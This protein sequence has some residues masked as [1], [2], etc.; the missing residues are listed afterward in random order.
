M[1]KSITLLSEM[2]LGRHFAMLTKMYFGALT[3]RLE[4]LE[5]DRHYSIL[6]L[7][8]KNPEKCTQQFISNELKIDK[9]SMVR[10][11]DYM[12]KKDFLKRTINPSDRREHRM[13][14]TAKA[15]K[16]MP[17]I[18]KEISNLNSAATKGLNNNQVK[19][20]YSAISKVSVNLTKEPAKR[21]IVNYKAKASSK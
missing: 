15:K 19:E 9:A 10:I 4:H 11:V 13:E 5:I 2:P 20:F 21:V 6:I 12:V 18:H 8:E 1:N 7:V 3:K 14:L 17:V 16:F